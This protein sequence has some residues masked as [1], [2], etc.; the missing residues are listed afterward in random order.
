L[1]EMV[2]L[3]WLHTIANTKQRAM[4]KLASADCLT[5]ALMVNPMDDATVEVRI[6]VSRKMKNLAASAWKPTGEEVGYN[7]YNVYWFTSLHV[8]VCS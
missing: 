1:S 6:K 4:S 8:H 2:K 3:H 7:V 5:R